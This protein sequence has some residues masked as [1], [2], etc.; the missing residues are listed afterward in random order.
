MVPSLLVAATLVAPAA[1]IPKDTLPNPTGPAP[2]ILA[3]KAN[4]AGGVTIVAMLYEKR[5]IQQQVVVNENG[6]Q[7][8]KQQEVE[9]MTTSYIQKSLGDFGGKFTMAD[10]S[11][12][13]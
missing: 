10:G 12:I 3:V 2:R 9:M 8:V 1:P 5:K 4:S 11:E 6:K 13:T 7:V